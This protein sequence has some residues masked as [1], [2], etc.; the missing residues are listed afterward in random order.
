MI[1]TNFLRG[2]DICYTRKHLFKDKYD[3][4][5]GK[6]VSD[7]SADMCTVRLF[8]YPP[9]FQN[10]RLV[11]V[12]LAFLKNMEMVDEYGNRVPRF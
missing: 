9:K 5:P 6:I 11:T 1:P 10:S 3:S 2:D 4:F 12:P 8:P 7:V